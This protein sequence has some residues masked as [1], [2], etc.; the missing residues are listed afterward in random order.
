MMTVPR[1]DVEVDIAMKNVE[2]GCY[3]WGN[4]LG[5]FRAALRWTWLAHHLP[6]KPG[7]TGRHQR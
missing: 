1:G 6:I 7:V 4:Y 3:L 5:L 2:N